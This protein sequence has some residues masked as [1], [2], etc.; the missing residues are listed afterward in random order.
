MRSYLLN[1]PQLMQDSSESLWDYTTY[2]LCYAYKI[3][4]SSVK[5]NFKDKDMNEGS[6]FRNFK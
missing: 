5:Y 6:R 3:K 1:G 2:S 4:D